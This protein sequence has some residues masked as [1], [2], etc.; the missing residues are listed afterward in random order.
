[1]TSG[2]ET[3]LSLCTKTR[4]SLAIPRTAALARTVGFRRE[5]RFARGA[6][7]WRSGLSINPLQRTAWAWLTLCD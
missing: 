4:S 2:P 3:A 6:V 5:R 1:M 7:G